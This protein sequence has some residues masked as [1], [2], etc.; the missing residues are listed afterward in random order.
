MFQNIALLLP[1]FKDSYNISD[2][3]V[4]AADLQPGVCWFEF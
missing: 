2:T 4:K 1:T 3:I